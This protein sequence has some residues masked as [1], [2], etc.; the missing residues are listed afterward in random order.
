MALLFFHRLIIVCI[1]T[2]LAAM[3]GGCATSPGLPDDFRLEV[4]DL[5]FQDIDC[6][7]LCNAIETV[8]EGVDGANFSHLGMVSSASRKDAM[9]IEAV[10]AGVVETPLTDFLARSTEPDGGSRV[11]VGRLT[12]INRFLI[13]DALAIARRYKGLPYDSIYV[14]ENSSFYCSELLYESYRQAAIGW[15]VFELAP[16]TFKDPA[17]GDF[18]P[19][20]VDYYRDLAVAI[21]EGKPG[22]NPGGMSRSPK[23]EIVHAYGAPSGWTGSK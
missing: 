19:A 1:V 6:G 2:S 16:M 11:L 3:V 8:T 14:M 21:P 18:F 15:P 4:G 23:I 10:S 12:G 7:P 5:L 17:T 22:L 9:V 13:S 20:W